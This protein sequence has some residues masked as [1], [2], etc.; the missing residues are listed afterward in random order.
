MIML[1]VLS[2]FCL[3]AIVS[4]LSPHPGALIR[5]STGAVDNAVKSIV[6]VLNQ[7]IQEVQIPDQSKKEHHIHLE[8]R[9]IKLEKFNID[10][11]RVGVTTNDNTVSFS[12]QHIEFKVSFHYQ[13]HKKHL[14]SKSGNC[15]ISVD[16]GH[17]AASLRLTANNGHPVISLLSKDAGMGGLHYKCH[18]DLFDHIIN[19]LSGVIKPE[20]KKAIDTAIEKAI[21][22][23]FPSINQKLAQIPTDRPLSNF[24]SAFH[25]DY[26]IF[27]QPSTTPQ[28]TRVS[29]LSQFYLDGHKDDNPP[30]VF[31]SPGAFPDGPPEG[32]FCLNIDSNLVFK[33]AAYAYLKSDKSTFHL[34]KPIFGKLPESKRKFF[35]CDCSGAL[36]L[37][38]LL[39]SLKST[40]KPGE[41]V[42]IHGT[43]KLGGDIKADDRGLIIS[44]EGDST[45]QLGTEPDKG[46]TLL[47]LNAS[48]GVLLEKSVHI[49]NWSLFGHVSVFQTHLSASTPAGAIAPAIVEK[50]WE[51]ALADLAQLVIN[52]AL[53]GGIPLPPLKFITFDKVGIKFTGPLVQVCSNVNIDFNKLI[54]I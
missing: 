43:V 3:I 24:L 6:D 36:C 45:F 40:C 2:F 34:D 39:P 10:R 46:I 53:G 21:S 7:H 49:Q 38:T 26:S 12:A 27:G 25:V 5:L 35:D 30:S 50:I 28:M 51:F 19:W 31:P 1:K 47:S 15:A 32:D 52:E 17:V 48:V 13:V 8:A 11:N 42:D 29:V 4:G 14:F 20:I 54:H 37:V 23:A 9:N 16:D 22:E 33:S 18:G 41:T 44:A